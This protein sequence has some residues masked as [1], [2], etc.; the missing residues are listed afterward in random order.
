MP[1]T[2][3]PS[4]RPAFAPLSTPTPTNAPATAQTTTA[5]TTTAPATAANPTTEQ[6]TKRSELHATHFAGTVEGAPP[7]SSH[8]NSSGPASVEG[9]SLLRKVTQLTR[10]QVAVAGLG[11]ALLLPPAAGQVLHPGVSPSTAAAVA[12]PL[13]MQMQQKSKTQSAA[14]VNAA[15]QRAVSQVGVGI[16]PARESA[17]GNVIAVSTSAQ[18]QAQQAR[19]ILSDARAT[20]NSLQA[21]VG[22]DAR[23]GFLIDLYWFGVPDANHVFHAGNT[24]VA[25]TN[26][27]ANE[28]D[29]AVANARTAARNEVSRL[30][31]DESPAFVSL[32]TELDQMGTQLALAQKIGRLAREASSDLS[33]AHYNIVRRNSESETM[34]VDVFS[35]RSVTSNGTTT[36]ER[37]RTGQRRVPNPAW[38][39]YK[40]KAQNWKYSAERTIRRLNDEINGSQG[41][42]PGA[43]FK[44]VDAS[45]LVA[46]RPF[47]SPVFDRDCV[48]GL[49]PKVKDVEEST[50]R[51]LEQIEERRGSLNT[52]MNHQIDVRWGSIVDG[53][54]AAPRS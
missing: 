41:I 5:Q 36:T 13:A 17:V 14:S 33:F 26:S 16:G 28:L 15:V 21:E 10:K 46:F 8:R 20:M 27:F 53:V 25:S 34:M 2:N 45:E 24:D 44:T 52:E 51:L 22:L 49:M 4:R 43:D 6:P 31:V 9:F 1:I 39:E 7:R 48:R 30:L 37:V 18:A 54:V 47:V 50:K 23:M 35:E 32:Q 12:S 42:L 29:T 11:L 3:D 38:E 40:S 19:S